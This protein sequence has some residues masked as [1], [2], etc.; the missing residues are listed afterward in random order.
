MQ[1]GTG[2]QDVEAAA[3]KVAAQEIGAA[4]ESWSAVGS[5]DAFGV[6]L[7]TN[8]MKRVFPRELSSELDLFGEEEPA[9]GIVG[10]ADEKRAQRL[11]RSTRLRSGS[12]QRFMSENKGGLAA[13]GG[14]DGD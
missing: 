9:R 12:R 5:E 6:Y 8:E 13:V 10:A 2:L 14:R 11:A 4:G 3:V 1:E 7:V